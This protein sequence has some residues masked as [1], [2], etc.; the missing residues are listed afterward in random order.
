M[1]VQIADDAEFQT[2]V[3]TLFN[4]DYDNSVG[5]ENLDRKPIDWLFR[6]SKYGELIPKKEDLKT[7]GFKAR[8]VRV[9][10]GGRLERSEEPR[11]VE[12]KVWGKQ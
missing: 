11:F 7:E 6:S 3:R 4:N 1:I 10:S 9:Y 5:L 8:Y 12:I 2:N